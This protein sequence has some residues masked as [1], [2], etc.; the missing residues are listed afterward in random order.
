MAFTCT[1]ALLEAGEDADLLAQGE[2]LG[3]TLQLAGSDTVRAGI[4]RT[5]KVMRELEAARP[6]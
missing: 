5:Q 6:R 1:V 2:K 4:R 3:V